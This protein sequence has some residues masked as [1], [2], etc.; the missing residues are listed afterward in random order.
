[1]IKIKLAQP[2]N[3]GLMDVNITRA[4][5][6]SDQDGKATCDF[7]INVYDLDQFNRVIAAVKKVR[8]VVSVQR[9][10]RS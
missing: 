6:F 1:M 7:S 10:S 2:W 4:D 9:I 3:F 5:T 8:G